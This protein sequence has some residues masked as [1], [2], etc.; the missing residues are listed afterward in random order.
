MQNARPSHFFCERQYKS[1]RLV[2]RIGFTQ[3][4]NTLDPGPSK[5]TRQNSA[6]CLL[7]TVYPTMVTSLP[8][9]L[10][11]ACLNSVWHCTSAEL[12]LLTIAHRDG[13]ELHAAGSSMRWVPC[14]DS[15]WPCAWYSPSQCSSGTRMKPT[16][17][18]DLQLNSLHL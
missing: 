16:F 1:V 9:Y 14:S 7:R 2:K 13:V 12:E 15:S 18:P 8:P 11:S 10:R 5:K 17:M 6:R 4:R 3:A